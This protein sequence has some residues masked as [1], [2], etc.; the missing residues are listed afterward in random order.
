MTQAPSLNG[1]VIGQAERATRALLDV[2]LAAENT[3][4]VNWVSLNLL[5]TL[6]KTTPESL[7]EQLVTGLRIDASEAQAAIDELDAAGLVTVGDLIALTTEGE[8]TYAHISAGIGEIS[9]RLY[10]DLPHDDLVIARQVL[11][12]L[13]DRARRELVT[14]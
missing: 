4:F 8:A 13:T 11:E 12:T 5:G 1:Q 14:R 7:V 6:G 3:P 10:R 2:L 9:A